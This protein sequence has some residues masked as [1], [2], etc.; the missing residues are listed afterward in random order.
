M[1]SEQINQGKILIVTTVYPLNADDNQGSFI[2]ARVVQL[3]ERADYLFTVFA[4]A[5]EGSKGYQLDGIDVLRFRYFLKPFENLVRDGAPTKLKK[6]PL[7][8]I[9]AGAYILLGSWQLFWQCLKLKP[10]LLHINWPF[11]HGLMA[12]P[13]SKLL[14][15]PMVFSFFGAELLLAERFSFVGR[16]FKWLIPQATVVTSNSSFT[17]SIVKRFSNAPVRVVFD[18]LTIEAKPK[19]THQAQ[20]IPILLFVG[21][22]D[23][24][25]IGPSK[26]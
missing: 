11:P 23:E 26:T 22:L 7:Y 18:G 13:A 12:I 8:L 9:V 21:R 5:Y 16:I 25:R 15:I 20:E 17:K 4:P 19:T 14:G 10:D 1:K 24:D 3:Q 6:Q 2:R